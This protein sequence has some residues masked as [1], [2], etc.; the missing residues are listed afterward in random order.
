M[1][2]PTDSMKHYSSSSI[3]NDA[4]SKM[5]F[6]SNNDDYN[7]ET[8]DDIERRLALEMEEEKEEEQTEI[9]SQYGA[10]LD[11][12]GVPEDSIQCEVFHAN[13]NKNEFTATR[14]FTKAEK[15]APLTETVFSD[16]NLSSYRKNAERSM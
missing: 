12:D 2:K 4:I 1:G 11:E 7:G 16:E 6:D 14:I 13:P 9:V 10:K 15:P 3:Q 5:V 8:A